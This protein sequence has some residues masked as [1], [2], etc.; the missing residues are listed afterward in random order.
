MTLTGKSFAV[1]KIWSPFGGVISPWPL[2]THDTRT[3]RLEK[4]IK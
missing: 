4:I 1:S 2:R 3:S